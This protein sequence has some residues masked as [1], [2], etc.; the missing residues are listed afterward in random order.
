MAE[1][2][3]VRRCYNCGK[4][5][6]CQDPAAPGYVRPEILANT[7]QKITF[8]D[9]CFESEKYHARPNEPL[10]DPDFLTILNDAKA[11][12]A[13][14]VYVINLFSFEASFNQQVDDLIRDLPL[15]VLANKRDL[16]PPSVPDDVLREYVFHRFRA[17]G[18]SA[19]EVIVSDFKKDDAFRLTVEKIL[20]M[21]GGHDVY[22]IGP[23]LSGKTTIIAA[24]LRVYTNL[25]R[26]NIVTENYHDT[27]LR[28]MKIPLDEQSYCY[29]TP[30]ISIDNS[31]LY[32]ADSALLRDI[33]LKSPVKV[34][35]IKVGRGQGVAIGG[36]SFIGLTNG[37][38]RYTTLNFYFHDRV[39]LKKLSRGKPL[40]KFYDLVRK[41]SLRPSGRRRKPSD[42]D[43]YDLVVDEQHLRDIGIQGFGWF[44]FRGRGQTF[45]IAVPKGVSIFTSRAKI[46][47]K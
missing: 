40:E 28:V 5:L 33:F 11:G 36:L 1:I 7:E 24:C 39:Q 23:K 14:I 15:L 2:T 45:R 21:R 25:T 12:D 42:F 41:G 6:Q 47:L 16:L 17:V 19:L 31:L 44:S 10:L 27:S 46:P 30:G 37:G 20:A 22:F 9:K 43:I 8:C 18:L 13:L 29:D 26:G 4:I 3:Q 32:N 35:S 38:G 34:R